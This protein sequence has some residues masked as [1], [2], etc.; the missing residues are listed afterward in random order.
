MELIF[1]L[2]FC[3]FLFFFFKNLIK[4]VDLETSHLSEASELILTLSEK[5]C[6]PQIL[7]SLEKKQEDVL[8]DL[9]T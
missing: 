8:N 9:L 6:D 2:C 4:D 5:N 1:K 7:R 3:L